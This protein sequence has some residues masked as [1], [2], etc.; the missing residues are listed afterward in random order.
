MA[1]CSRVSVSWSGAGQ[2][3]HGTDGS[4]CQGR[5]ASFVVFANADAAACHI[6]VRDSQTGR[7]SRDVALFQETPALV[8]DSGVDMVINLTAGMG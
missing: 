2:F 4:F 8:R 1:F 5:G 3:W 6:H 7:G